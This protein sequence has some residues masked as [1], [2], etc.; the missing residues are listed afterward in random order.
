MALGIRKFEDQVAIDWKLGL[1][2]LHG[3]KG[4]IGIR[5]SGFRI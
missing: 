2:G 4:Y 1:K 5:I 3:F